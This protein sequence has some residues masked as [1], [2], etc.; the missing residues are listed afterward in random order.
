[1]V[2]SGGQEGV[3]AVSRQQGV[4]QRPPSNGRVFVDPLHQRLRGDSDAQA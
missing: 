2:P 3:P 1:M 4:K